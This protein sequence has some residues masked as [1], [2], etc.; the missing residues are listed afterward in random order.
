MEMLDQLVQLSERRNKSYLRLKKS[1]DEFRGS[2]IA[3][4]DGKDQRG[5]IPWIHVSGDKDTGPL[6]VTYLGRQFVF[7]FSVSLLDTNLV[8]NVVVYEQNTRIENVARRA[9][10]ILFQ[11]NS[12]V[13]DFPPYSDGDPVY[14]GGNTADT[15]YITLQLLEKA[16]T[17]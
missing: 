17:T 9:A 10:A 12:L 5:A 8:G 1:F 11:T 13:S 3:F 7:E 4:F 14:L 2:A 6:L 16:I 15:I